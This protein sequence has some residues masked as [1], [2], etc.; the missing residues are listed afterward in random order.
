MDQLFSTQ[1]A[2]PSKLAK[3]RMSKDQDSGL[4]FSCGAGSSDSDSVL[5]Y[6]KRLDSKLMSMDNKLKKLDSLEDRVC[7]FDTEVRKMWSF[8]H[9]TLKQSDKKVH[10]LGERKDNVEFSLGLV[11]EKMSNLEQEN[12]RVKD[13]LLYLQSQSMRNNLV[14]GNI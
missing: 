8:I 5:S 7:K 2:S 3:S 10:S 12:K 14:F 1:P 13:D 4:S 6:L 11:R 9:E